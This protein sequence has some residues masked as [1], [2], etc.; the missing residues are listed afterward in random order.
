[1]SRDISEVFSIEDGMP[2]PEPGEVLESVDT[3]F[4]A[5]LL[6]IFCEGKSEFY[7]FSGFRDEINSSR[8][9]I[10]PR[11]PDQSQKEGSDILSLTNQA[12]N[13]ISTKKVI[14]ENSTSEEFD[15][16]END[17]FKILFDCDENF[18]IKND[19]KS[20]YQESIEMMDDYNIELFLSN[21]CFE[22]WVLC[23]FKKPERS[24]KLTSL[25]NQ[26]KAETGWT[27]YKKSD[28]DIFNKIGENINIAVKNSLELIQERI[29]AGIDLHSEASNPVTEI[30]CL[31]EQINS[32][33]I[34]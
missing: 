23:H 17:E 31:V 16:D 4:D 20:K 7:Y 2:E 30:G 28:K 21:Y 5:K 14:V 26:I 13:S 29:N 1:M 27:R 10:I 25:K 12:I 32:T 22:V 24:G 15:V 19:R 11:I 6:F 33:L 18:K 9:K 34:D 8:I 3:L